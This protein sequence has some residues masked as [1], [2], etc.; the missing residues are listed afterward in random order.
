MEETDTQEIRDTQTEWK[1]IQ[2][3]HTVV[4]NEG[5][6]PIRREL[7][8]DL[9]I[10]LYKYCRAKDLLEKEFLWIIYSKTKDFFLSYAPE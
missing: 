2:N 4:V 1:F 5:F 9:Q 3:Q 10:L 6:I 8:F 7:Y